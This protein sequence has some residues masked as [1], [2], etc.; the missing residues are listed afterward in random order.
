MR[1]AGFFYGLELMVD[2]DAR[3]DLTDEQKAVVCG[4]VLPGQ[5]QQAGLMTRADDRGPAMLMLSPP[6]VAD[7]AVLD[8]LFGM[9]DA[10]L[11]G[12]E[13]WMSAHGM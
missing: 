8:E 3:R 9:V 7:Q 10:V 2:R 4:E 6:L 1:G 12:T 13:S 11:D 5:M